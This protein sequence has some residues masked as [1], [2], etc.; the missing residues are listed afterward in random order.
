L[1]SSQRIEI[2]IRLANARHAVTQLRKARTGTV[3]SAATADIALTLSTH[4]GA[5]VGGGDHKSGR[6]SRMFHSAV[7][8]LALEGMI[9]LY[10]LVVLSPLLV[11]V[12]L[13]W[14]LM[15]ERRRRDERRLLTST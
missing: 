15:R 3:A 1:S 10:A 11:I 7:G 4:K 12:G 13:A 14:A 6:L 9:V 8:F 5:F 2:Q